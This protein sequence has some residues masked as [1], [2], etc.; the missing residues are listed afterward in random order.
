MKQLNLDLDQ[1]G[2]KNLPAMSIPS[3]T[4]DKPYYP[5]FHHEGEIDWE[6]AGITDEGTMTIR[7]CITRSTEIKAEDKPDVYTY[8]VEVREI[9]SV[10]PEK[11]EKPAKSYS[12]DTE[13]S[14]DKL[15]ADAM[16]KAKK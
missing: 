5:T 15:A 2:Q 3:Q 11:D 12:K 6:D 14:L 4:P 10:E 8:E 13:D 1:S 16:K 7:Y 9:V